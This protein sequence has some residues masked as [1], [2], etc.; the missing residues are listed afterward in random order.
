MRAVLMQRAR[1][2][3]RPMI[4]RNHVF[5]RNPILLH[6]DRREL[7]GAFNR[8]LLVRATLFTHL[9]PYRIPISRPIKIRVFA[10]LR[11][12]HVLDRHPLIDGK[13]PDQITYPVSPRSLCRTQGTPFQC[14][15]M[16]LRSRSVILRAVNGDVTR[17]HRTHHSS[18]MRAARNH[19]HFQSHI[20]HHRRCGNFIS[21]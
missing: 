2:P 3:T 8:R 10:L 17:I 4:M 21:G 6:Q 16:L 12:R 7:R 14:Q 20:P 13:M 15:R 1:S 18:A 19:V 11:G 9:D 5:Q